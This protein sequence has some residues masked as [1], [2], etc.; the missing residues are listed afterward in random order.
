MHA[1]TGT[2]LGLLPTKDGVILKSQALGGYIFTES[3]R[4][5]VFQLVVNDVTVKDQADPLPTILKA[6]QDEG[7]ISAILWR[8]Y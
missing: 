4:T 1:K 2:F 6:F 7:K 3:G 5:L 8:D